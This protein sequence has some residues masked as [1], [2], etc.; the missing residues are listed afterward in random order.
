MKLTAISGC[1][2]SLRPAG[3]IGFLRLSQPTSIGTIMLKPIIAAVL[4]SSAASIVFAQ[5]T[6]AAASAPAAAASTPPKHK[7]LHAPK[8]RPGAKPAENPEASPDKKGGN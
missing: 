1:E 3:A 5:A 2:C 8:L 4:L 7:F 6:T